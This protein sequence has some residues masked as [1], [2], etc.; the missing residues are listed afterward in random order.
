MWLISFH[1]QQDL[2]PFKSHSQHTCSGGWPLS[3]HLSSEH[4]PYFWITRDGEIFFI[5][6]YAFWSIMIKICKHNV[7][8]KYSENTKREKTNRT[9]G[10]IWVQR[11]QILWR[12]LSGRA[13]HKVLNKPC[14]KKQRWIFQPSQIFTRLFWSRWH[15]E[16]LHIT[17]LETSW[18]YHNIRV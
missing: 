5:A 6:R 10:G 16:S 8:G 18:E 7:I 1:I 3:L 17:S 2:V 15:A 9:S 13:Q 14:I 4:I 11:E 12:S